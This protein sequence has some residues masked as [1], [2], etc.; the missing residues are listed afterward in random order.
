MPVKSPLW[1]SISGFRRSFLP[2]LALLCGAGGLLHGAAIASF[3][4]YD[5][6]N[7]MVADHVTAIHQDGKGYLW[8]GTKGGLSRFDGENF[9]NFNL[10]DDAAS[11][12]VVKIFEDGNGQIWFMTSTGI[13]WY[14]GRDFRG[15]TTAGGLPD[16]AVTAMIQDRQGNLWFGTK[17]GIAVLRDM[18]ITPEGIDVERVGSAWKAS[19]E[20]TASAATHHKV[21]D[22]L[23]HVEGVTHVIGR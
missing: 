22:V 17:M 8:L 3:A 15:L 18:K 1:V 20:F 4:R 14:D 7:G 10:A 5:S 16:N 12:E 21:L 2:A 19:F 11:D 23:A 6:S 13:K 9:E